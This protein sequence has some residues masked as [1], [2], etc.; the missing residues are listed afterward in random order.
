[1]NQLWLFKLEHKLLKISVDLQTTLA[2]E[3]YA[4][5][6]QWLEEQLNMGM[7]RVFRAEHE[8]RLFLELRSII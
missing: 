7:L 3:T 8:Y 4:A 2:T 6:G 5:E 1:V